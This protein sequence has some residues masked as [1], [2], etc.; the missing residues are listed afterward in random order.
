[1]KAPSNSAQFLEDD[2]T[3]NVLSSTGDASELDAR[4]CGILLPRYV[5]WNLHNLIC[6]SV[7]DI[8][9]YSARFFTLV[10]SFCHAHIHLDKCYLLDPCD[11]L[12]SGYVILFYCTPFTELH[13]DTSWFILNSK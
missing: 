1:M 13:S 4:G 3:A 12:V 9:A 7:Q 8:N 10:C 2:L 5:Y 11:A 6:M